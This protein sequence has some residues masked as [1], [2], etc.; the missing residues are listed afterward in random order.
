MTFDF[1]NKT[2]LDKTFNNFE[3][4]FKYTYY[5]VVKKSDRIHESRLCT[6]TVRLQ[7]VRN[8]T[9]WPRPPYA[10]PPC[11]FRPPKSPIVI[12]VKNVYYNCSPT[13]F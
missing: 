12:T 3:Y 4:I 8:C 13:S 7:Y 11:K 5:S 6:S 1:R 10:C 9:T 2:M